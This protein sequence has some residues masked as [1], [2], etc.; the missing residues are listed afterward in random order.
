[1]TGDAAPA[2]PVAA[3]QP[4]PS[5]FVK[6]LLLCAALGVAVA[7]VFVAFEA[8][9]EH[10]REWLWHTV[11]GEHPGWAITIGITTLGA[12]AMG[13][14]LRFL[15]G[16]GGPHPAESHG[17]GE[18]GVDP[19]M[20]RP[21]VIGSV[22][23]VGFLGLAVGA[24]L[25]PEGAILPAVV[26]VSLL[27]ARLGRA[28]GRVKLLVQGAGLGSLLAAMFGSPLAGVVP[29]LEV[30][31]VAP[32]AAMAL[33]VLPA[34]TASATATITLH[35]LDIEPAGFLPFTYDT[36]HASHLVWAVLI[37][38]VA[39]AAGLLVDRAMHLFRSFTRRLD[40]T[41]VVLTAV[42]GG[43]GLGLLYVLGG[44]TVRFSGIPELVLA[45]RTTTSP[46]RAL[47]LAAVK[48][49]AT[50]WCLAAGFRGG[51]I[52]P[53]AYIGG[54]VGLSLHLF[55]HAIPVEVAWGVGLAAAMATALGTPVLAV[56][57]VA[58]VESPAML[59]LAV[60]GVVAAP[61]V[62]L[63]GDQLRAADGAV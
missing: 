15:P 25:G 53:A 12:L 43:L 2:P 54:M 29:L 32:G 35:V 14:G 6:L 42:A 19:A 9:L 22:L 23:V 39:G 27:A 56:L 49:T 18:A 62:H 45:V 60:I 20:G 4:K 57:V 40:R 17:I 47:L 1:M 46:W 37:G 26:G 34:L 48:V 3:E 33:L 58:S 7:L 21:R 31:P 36:F 44:E 55:V 13:L 59:P 10:T 24:S 30:V 61:T 16:H 5:A 28:E 52:F 51:K 50:A 41:S 38:V 8:A 11:A 63:L